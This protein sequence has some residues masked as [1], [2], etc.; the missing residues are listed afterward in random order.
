M[1]VFCAN[2]VLRKEE[3][4][5]RLPASRVPDHIFC[6]AQEVEGAVDAPLWLVG[7]AARAPDVGACAEAGDDSD[8][9]SAS[10]AEAGAAQ[11]GRGEP[12]DDAASNSDANP[13]LD[14]AEESIALHP[15]RA[16]SPVRM[17][18]ALQANIKAL[19]EHVATVLRKEQGQ[20]PKQRRCSST[21]R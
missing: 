19:Q 8:E 13:Q 6:C 3:A 10:E 7:R 16:E 14:L 21:C 11:P 15:V 18:R 1:S 2:V 9:S 12:E 20:H 17:M 4:S 5:T